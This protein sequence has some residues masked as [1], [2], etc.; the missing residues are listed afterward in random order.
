M[1]KIGL[2]KRGG[3]WWLTSL[4][5][6]LLGLA[7]TAA[8]GATVFV[9]DTAADTAVVDGTCSL[10]EAITALNS[11]TTVDTCVVGAPAAPY[12]IRFDAA[13]T[14]ISLGSQLPTVTTP[15]TIDA[16]PAGTCA[17][18]PATFPVMLSGGGPASFL[19][20]YFG[21]GSQGSVV[22]GLVLNAFSGAIRLDSSGHEIVCNRLGTDASGLVAAPNRDGVIIVDGSDN[23]IGTDGDGSDDAA[24]GNVIAASERYGV[25]ARGLSENTVIAG[26]LV[27]LG[28]DGT[29]ALGNAQIGIELRNVDGTRIGTN[30][31]GIS[32][33]VEGNVI[34]ANGTTPGSEGLGIKYDDSGFPALQTVI[35]GN[36][37]GTDASG[38]LARPNGHPSASRIGGVLIESGADG[39][40]IGTNADGVSDALERNLIA[41]N[42][43]HG[44]ILAARTAQ[45]AGN[46]IGLDATGLAPLG[47]DVGIAILP[48][49]GDDNV[50]GTNGDGSGD[51][52]EG[53]FISGNLRWGV[54]IDG[55]GSTVIAQNNRI[56]GNRFGFGADGVTPVGQ[57]IAVYL[58]GRT[59]GTLIGADGNGTSD[60]LEVNHF[61]NNNAGLLVQASSGFSNTARCNL[62][63]RDANGAP[64]PNDFAVDHFTSDL[65]LEANYLHFSRQWGARQRS[66]T[67]SL[68]PG[69]HNVISCNNEG[70][71][72][73]ALSPV[74]AAPDIW[75][76]R[77][78][79]PSGFGPGTGDSI[80]ANVDPTAYLVAPPTA[81]G[82]VPVDYPCEPADLR[83]TKVAD[84]PTVPWGGVVTYT[85]TVT[86]DGPGT[87]EGVVVNDV[88]P[89]EL[90]AAT[91]TGCLN[92]PGGMPSCQLPDLPAT[93]SVA[94]TI[95]AT[96]APGAGVVVNTATVTTANLDPDPSDDAATDT[97]VGQPSVL[98]IPTLGEWGAGVL[99]LL[100]AGFGW[101]A[102]RNRAAGLRRG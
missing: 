49:D 35:A 62:F 83:I 12:T 9:V 68:P 86:N 38:L 59:D 89:V 82:L 76:G 36:K 22:R 56:A 8:P 21:A 45:V 20:L 18:L 46:W 10:R 51:A 85:L 13:V 94:F 6:S 34:S 72:N 50:I 93:T 25:F 19:G 63:G 84:A 41:A 87:A 3:C 27:G 95:T 69:N 102:L 81:C 67:L 55:R 77:A 23:V 11:A 92:D 15:V 96:V 40:R 57:Q 79:G 64:A 26:N 39:T 91:T 31:D 1:A 29:T 43:P 74:L 70:L 37:I 14:A 75:W 53:N 16:T 30:G 52:L 60:A 80:S 97:I 78:N 44:L 24:E 98:E 42:L 66:G 2:A 47:N 48:G 28:A 58:L 61:G 100:L 4:S 71:D 99:A 54:M 5:T 65:V 88:L 90:L 73:F 101:L 32:D 7:G 17:S 33:A